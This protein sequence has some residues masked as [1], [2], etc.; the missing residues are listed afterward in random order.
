MENTVSGNRMILPLHSCAACA[1]IFSKRIPASA[2]QNLKSGRTKMSKIKGIH[3]VAIRCSGE[4]QLDQA[5]EFYTKVLGLS[6]LRSWGEGTGRGVMI[7]VGG[8]VIEM[9]ADAGPGRT[10]GPVD[11]LALATDDVDG[12]IEDVR[13]AGYP[14]T[15]E[16]GDIVIGSNPPFPARIAFCKGAAGEL[17]EIFHEK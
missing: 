12:V 7:D 15:Q 14:V 2:S 1:M 9:F 16:P 3:H 8:D 13:K 10:I 6:V 17:I 4:A 5:I 11:H